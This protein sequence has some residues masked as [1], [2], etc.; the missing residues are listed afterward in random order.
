MK[1]LWW[2]LEQ[3]LTWQGCWDA[4]RSTPLPL[5]WKILERFAL[6]ASPAQIQSA[7]V[8]TIMMMMMIMIMITTT[9]IQITIITIKTFPAHDELGTCRPSL[10]SPEQP[11]LCILQGL[12]T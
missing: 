1:H 11:V 10:V 5:L 8:I 2:Q 9:Q 12:L 3:K 6:L 4:S 7:P